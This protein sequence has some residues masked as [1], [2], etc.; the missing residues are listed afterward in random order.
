MS[1]ETDLLA[2]EATLWAGGPEAY[3]EHC[4]EECLV[5]F[6]EMAGMMARDEIAGMAEA[7]R[8]RDVRIARKAF[9]MLTGG[10]AV[11][12]YDCS[13]TRADGHPYRAYVTSTYV[14]REDGWKLAAHQQ[15]PIPE[16]PVSP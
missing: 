2:I 5:V 14:K 1:L 4:A 10:S 13:A 7:G 16:R 12:A 6:A 15:T 11:V 8:W 9:T 3:R